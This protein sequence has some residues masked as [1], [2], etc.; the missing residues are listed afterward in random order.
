M[1]DSGAMRCPFGSLM[2][3]ITNHLDPV[4]HIEVQH[5]IQGD[6]CVAAQHVHERG[7]LPGRDRRERVREELTPAQRPVLPVE[8]AHQAGQAAAV[9]RAEL[10]RVRLPYAARSVEVIEGM[11]DL[12]AH[13]VRGGR[14]PGANDDLAFAI[15]PGAGIPGRA[16]RRQRHPVQA[17]HVVQV[18]HAAGA[19]EDRIKAVGEALDD[20]GGQFG[21]AVDGADHLRR[22]DASRRPVTAQHLLQRAAV[23]VAH[24]PPRRARSVPGQP[25]TTTKPA[26]P[27]LHG[28]AGGALLAAGRVSARAAAAARGRVADGG[29][30]GP[31]PA[32][33][34]RPGASVRAG[35]AGPGT[36]GPGGPGLLQRRGEAARCPAAAPRHGFCRGRVPTGAPA[37][38]AVPPSGA[39]AVARSPRPG[40]GCPRPPGSV[41]ILATAASGGCQRAAAA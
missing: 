23:P 1:A 24:R 26:L 18:G 2:T 10:L 3:N 19:H 20:R 35:L 38:A 9:Q 15:G 40:R 7:P 16:P 12:V 31:G 6:P 25:G 11:A 28:H 8:V 4:A 22:R 14:G 30:G 33:P 29:P 17:A 34:P 36:A 27:G 5:D 32:G 37:A 21:Q 13:H 41:P 39:P